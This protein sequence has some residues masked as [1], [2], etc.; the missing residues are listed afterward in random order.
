MITQSMFDEDWML[1][2]LCFSLGQVEQIC[3]QSLMLEFAQQFMVQLETGYFTQ[4]VIK[5][6]DNDL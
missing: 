2:D 1:L 6:M 3:G 4:K 5:D